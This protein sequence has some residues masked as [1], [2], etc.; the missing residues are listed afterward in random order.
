MPNWMEMSPSAHTFYKTLYS[1]NCHDEML[2]CVISLPER[3]YECGQL[4]FIELLLSAAHGLTTF[5][6]NLIY[7]SQEPNKISTLI[8]F[9]V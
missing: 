7:F 5:K 6:D 4:I 9:I 8:I 3:L 2:P 1:Y